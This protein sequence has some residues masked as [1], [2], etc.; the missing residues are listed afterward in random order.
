MKDPPLPPVLYKFFG[1]TIASTE[2]Q[3]PYIESNNLV[4]FTPPM[5]FNDPF[6]S[7]PIWSFQEVEKNDLN[8]F[9][10]EHLVGDTPMSEGLTFDKRRKFKAFKR[11]F[12]KREIRDNPEILTEMLTKNAN[13]VASQATGVL[14]LSASWQT[15]P[16]WAHYAANHEGFCIGFDASYLFFKHRADNLVFKVE[17]GTERPIVPVSRVFEGGLTD[18]MYEEKDNRWSYEEEFRIVKPLILASRSAGDDKRGNPIKLFSLPPESVK[19]IIVGLHCTS[20]VRDRVRK[21]REGHPHVELYEAVISKK[22]YSM[23]RRIL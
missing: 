20:D 13:K 21:W 7:L 18:A 14:S 8:R 23:D 16:M 17:Y 5:S 12:A 10:E 19:E 6:E 15:S 2:D 4:R 9:I 11:A 22:T 3:I 1:P